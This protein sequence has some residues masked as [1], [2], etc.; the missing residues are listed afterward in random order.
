MGGGGGSSTLMDE[1]GSSTAQA[2]VVL[3]LA[4]GILLGSCCTLAWVR[5]R[6]QARPLLK[7]PVA[8][9]RMPIGPAAEMPHVIATTAAVDGAFEMSQRRAAERAVLE[10]A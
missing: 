4:L 5:Y 10:R 2:A 3:G 1:L 9:T 8:V 6:R 7:P